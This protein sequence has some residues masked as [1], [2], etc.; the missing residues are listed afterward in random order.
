MNAPGNKPQRS[1]AS[2]SGK[3]K[4]ENSK[5]MRI[6]LTQGERNLL[7]KACNKYR[8]TIPPYIKSRQPETDMLEAIIGKL[9]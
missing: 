8:Y 5:S 6:V 3:E 2:L 4:A 9:S 7:L 1:K